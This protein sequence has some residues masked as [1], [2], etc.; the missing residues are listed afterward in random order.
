VRS[1]IDT[2]IAAVAIQ[3]DAVLVHKDKDFDPIAAAV[4]RL[5]VERLHD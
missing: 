5:R 4:P 2:L 1:S 3:R